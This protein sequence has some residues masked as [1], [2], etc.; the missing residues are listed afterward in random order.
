MYWESER[1]LYRPVYQCDA[2]ALFRIYG[3]PRTHLFN[4][5]GPHPDIQY[6][7]QS[8][9]QRIIN[10]TT[11]GFGDW[12]IMSKKQPT[13]I[14]GFGGVFKS[15]FNG[16]MTNNLGYR[17]EPEAWGRGYATEL[18]LTAVGYG[19]AELD[20][21]EIV[22]VV[23]ENHLASRR[24]LQKAGLRFVERINDP[25][26]PPAALLFRLSLEEWLNPRQSLPKQ[27]KAQPIFLPG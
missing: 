9:R 17:F 27:A 23:R 13:R 26:D 16:R 15:E 12:A 1:L 19:F 20:L 8:I 18:A 22:G 7:R 6:S 11:W 14:I 25:Q 10:R 5:H 4:P 24:V 3:D 2:E 21:P